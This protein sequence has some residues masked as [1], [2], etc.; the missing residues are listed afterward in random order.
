MTPK[1]PPNRNQINK[2]IDATILKIEGKNLSNSRTE[3]NQGKK[4]QTSASANSG[5]VSAPTT[6]RLVSITE[7]K[8]KMR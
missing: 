1:L 8:E 6:P 3:K 5:S 7:S 4:N 2:E